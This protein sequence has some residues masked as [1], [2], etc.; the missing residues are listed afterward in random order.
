MASQNSKRL[1]QNIAL[2]LL[3]AGLIFFITTRREDRGAMFATLYDKSIGDNAKEVV[4]HAEGRADLILKNKQGVWQ[5]T[6]PESFIAD[7]AKVQH[8]FTLL[9]ENAESHYDIKGKDLASYGLD[10]DRLSVSFN[11]VKMI[12]GKLNEVARKRYILKGDKMYLIEETVS[13]LM[14][15]G[16]EAF[17]PQTPIKMTPEKTP[18]KPLE[19]KP[20]PQ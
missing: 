7:K 14:E 2:L 4:I 10:K 16:V 18:Q 20:A 13:G 3:V 11:G 17:K 12:F 1:I 5:V 8:L 15:M 6:N 9:S 19:S